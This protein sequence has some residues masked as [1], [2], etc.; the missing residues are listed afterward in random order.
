MFFRVQKERKREKESLRSF[1]FLCLIISVVGFG[2][3]VDESLKAYVFSSSSLILI[4]ICFV[5]F[6]KREYSGWER[7]KPFDSQLASPSIRKNKDP[8]VRLKLHYCGPSICMRS[9]CLFLCVCVCEDGNAD[10]L[11][12]IYSTNIHLI[13]CGFVDPKNRRANNGK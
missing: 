9:I 11:G 3:K 13:N 6:L 1:G 12:V 2:K 7:S 10:D 8:L 5:E 4:V